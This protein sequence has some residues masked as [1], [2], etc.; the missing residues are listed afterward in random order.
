MHSSAASL[1]RHVVGL[2]AGA[3]T[4]L[5]GW[6]QA[7][8][9]AWLRAKGLIASHPS[10]LL[11]RLLEELPEVLL[12]EVLRRLDPT[13]L[14][15]FAR[16]GRASRAAVASSGLPRAGTSEGV[17]FKLTQFCASVERLAWAKA[18]DCPWLART[19]A[20]AA[21]GGRAEVL[22]WAREHGC[23]WDAWTCGNAAKGG[24]MEVLK[25]AREH[26]CPWEK[27]ERDYPTVDCCA[28]TAQG[29]HLE[30]LTW[31]RE[32]E[33]PLDVSTCACAAQ[34]GHLGVLMW[35]R[36]HNCPWYGPKDSARHVIGCR[37]TLESR[38]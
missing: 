32:H 2:A 26:G 25:W 36:E 37:L 16:T 17:A 4:E 21:V 33:C 28:L 12:A 11:G 27:W 10:P 29:G 7:K 24:H 15:L 3:L 23:D 14:A 8:L 9:L 30:V 13:D 38:V 34:G 19:C 35:A 1:P 5:L 6:L 31:L 20:V 18:N 22:R